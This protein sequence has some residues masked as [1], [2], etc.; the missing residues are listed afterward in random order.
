MD[1]PALDLPVD[2]IDYELRLLIAETSFVD[3]YEAHVPSL[4]NDRFIGWFS[5]RSFA[6]C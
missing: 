5:C 6:A 4:R 1:V 3:A 2:C